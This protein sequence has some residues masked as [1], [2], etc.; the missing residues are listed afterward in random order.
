MA[1]A[2][3]IDKAVAAV[4][5]ETGNAS[6]L[7]CAIV[8]ALALSSS[9][10][11]LL[12]TQIENSL[13]ALDR[14]LDDILFRQIRSKIQQVRIGGTTVGEL[15]SGRDVGIEALNA[16]TDAA[17]AVLRRI[18]FGRV[19]E[20]CPMV[21]NVLKTITRGAGG[22]GVKVDVGSLEDLRLARNGL[23]YDLHKFTD[24]DT[25]L[26]LAKTYITAQKEKLEQWVSILD[27][28]DTIEGT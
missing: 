5:T 26:N 21:D 2:D 11:R 19:A 8:F 3:L 23:E 4:G 6:G 14:G 22:I 7:R 9:Q 24:L 15:A 25:G 20:E 13:A 10:R 28:L 1:T 18:P 16:K 17:A 27:V 12:R